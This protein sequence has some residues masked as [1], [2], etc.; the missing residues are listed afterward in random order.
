MTIRQ[1]WIRI[2]TMLRN[3]LP[4]VGSMNSSWTDRPL[5]DTANERADGSLSCCE[6]A[7]LIDPD[8]Q[9]W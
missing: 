5:P 8:K 3:F 9:N 6:S 1:R 2:I 4:L 7:C